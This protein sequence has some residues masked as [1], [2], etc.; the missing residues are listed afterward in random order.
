MCG[1]VGWISWVDRQD[2]AAR[3][4]VVEAMTA[5]M[6]CRGPDG[7]G[8]WLDAHAALGHRRLAIIDLP[9]GRQPMAA[10]NGPGTAAVL[11][12]SGEV[13][14]YLELRA[15]LGSR[16]H[17]F[18]TES[19]TEVVLRAYLEW[20]EDFVHRLNGVYAF[21]LWD[22]AERRLLLVR[23]RMGVKPLY[24]YPLPGGV[25]FGSEPKAIL[26]KDRKSV[27]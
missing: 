23:D 3:R 26:A 10:V 19:D 16:G 14:N 12:Y 17:V 15:E 7:T 4:A 22:Q 27:V 25:L 20:G 6:A 9:G 24:Y 11:T 18:E 2:D 5:T 1:I 8:V 21:A 13:Y